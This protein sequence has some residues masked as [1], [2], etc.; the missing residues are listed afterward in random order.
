MFHYVVFDLSC[1]DCFG[2]AIVASN[3]SVCLHIIKF[4]EVEERFNFIVHGFLKDL[5]DGKLAVFKNIGNQLETKTKFA[6]SKF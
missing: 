5:S 4:C 2:I 1:T 6:D 3:Y